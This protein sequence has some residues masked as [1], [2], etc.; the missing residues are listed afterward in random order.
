[1]ERKDIA[2]LN[3]LK[4]V[5]FIAFNVFCTT[6][7]LAEYEERKTGENAACMLFVD[8]EKRVST[9][10]MQNV[11]DFRF[12]ESAMTREGACQ[13]V[14]K[15]RLCGCDGCLG[16]NDVRKCTIPTI[17]EVDRQ[18][19]MEVTRVEQKVVAAIIF[20]LEGESQVLG[21]RGKMSTFDV[22]SE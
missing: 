3:A 7:N 21:K 16:V 13:L 12:W 11:R 22:N 5:P 6:S 15:P 9:T 1:V 8:R 19:K 17:S 10:S 18:E 4:S 14:R 20:D 2:V